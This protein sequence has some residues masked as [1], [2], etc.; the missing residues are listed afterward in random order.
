MAPEAEATNRTPAGP[1]LFDP[2]QHSATF[3][4]TLL[5][6]ESGSPSAVNNL[7]KSL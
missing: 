5:S 3:K 4:E 6:K 1:I 7:C 2:V